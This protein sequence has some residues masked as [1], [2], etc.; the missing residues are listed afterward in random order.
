MAS[1]KPSTPERGLVFRIGAALSDPA[2]RLTWRNVFLPVYC[3][4]CDMRLLTEENGFF[5]PDCWHKAPW[6]DPPYCPLCGK[7]HDRMVG[8]GNAPNFPC[9]GCRERPAK[10]ITRIL[11]AARYDGVVKQ[12][13][14]L[15]KFQGKR[16]LA[17]PLAESMRAHVDREG[18]PAA[19]YDLLI[20]VPL[21]RVRLRERGFN[22]SLLLLQELLQLFP[23]AKVDESLQRIRPTVAQSTLKAE[24]RA[25]NVR[26]A[27]AVVG[28]TVKGRIVLMVDDVVTTGGTVGECARVLRRAGAARVDV[29]SAALARPGMRLDW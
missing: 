6:I 11:A 9:A 14:R 5:C 10:H 24:E 16:K 28:D 7:P 22:Q 4:A 20:P 15:F 19:A 3:K 21:H 23:G 1:V 26:G 2:W 8:L 13:V 12:A 25:A 17:E 18:G 27:F 29:L